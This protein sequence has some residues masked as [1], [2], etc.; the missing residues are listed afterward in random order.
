MAQ[1]VEHVRVAQ[2]GQHAVGDEVDGRFMAGDEQ[3]AGGGQQVFAGHGRVR[4]AVG[5]QPG[6]QVI[7]RLAG[8]GVGES[9]D[10][11]AKLS[12]DLLPPAHS[13]F[14]RPRVGISRLDERVGPLRKAR[15]VLAG[16]A[17]QLADRR[18]RQ[19]V[20]EVVD[21]VDAVLAREVVDQRRWR[22][23]PARGACY[24]SAR[25]C[26]VARMAALPA[27]GAGHGSGGS[28]LINGCGSPGCAFV[29][30][31]PGT[32]EFSA[33]AGIGADP[34]I[35]QQRDDLVSTC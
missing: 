27:R 20:G 8:A 22:F 17:E 33:A 21:D 15:L 31:R 24:R 6:D 9:V 16:D 11:V 32:A 2:Q 23:R 3:Q 13:L 10:V 25:G 7:A 18:D 14:E 29:G 1:P 35:V 34:R 5:E 28:W 4:T 12:V 30:S 26:G 19:R